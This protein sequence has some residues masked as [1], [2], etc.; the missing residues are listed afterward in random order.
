MTNVYAKPTSFHLLHSLRVKGTDLLVRSWNESISCC[1][2]ARSRNGTL[3]PGREP[4]KEGVSFNRRV[5]ISQLEGQ[6]VRSTTLWGSAIFRIYHPND[7]PPSGRPNSRGPQL[8]IGGESRG[9]QLLPIVRL[10][11]LSLFVFWL[12]LQS[13][14]L[15]W[16]TLL[17]GCWGDLGNGKRQRARKTSHLLQKKRK[18]P[19]HPAG[20]SRLGTEE[21]VKKFSNFRLKTDLLQNLEYEYCSNNV[22]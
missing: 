7:V 16:L 6:N 20:L 4:A 8:R 22:S 12:A 10:L 3:A 9:K 2:Q 1:G 15:S 13:I 14:Y 17:T 21:V 11:L 19:H 18:V 5:R